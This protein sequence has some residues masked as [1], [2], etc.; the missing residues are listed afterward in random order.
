VKP[1]VNISEEPGFAGLLITSDLMAPKTACKA[2]FQRSPV[3]AGRDACAS[4]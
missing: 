1:E 4:Y 2:A 3:H